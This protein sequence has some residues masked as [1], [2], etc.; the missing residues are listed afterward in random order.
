MNTKKLLSSPLHKMVEPL[1]MANRA[2]SRFEVT[3]PG[4][5]PVVNVGPNQVA[6]IVANSKSIAALPT[7]V[8]NL[9]NL[10]GKGLDELSEQGVYHPYVSDIP[11][12]EMVSA[13]GP[14]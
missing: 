13:P 11:A 4:Y 7:Y 10:S 3:N 5:H 6:T 14:I 1:A 12:H 2:V 8:K 9:F